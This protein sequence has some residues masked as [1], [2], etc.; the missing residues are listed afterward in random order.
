MAKKR[1]AFFDEEKENEPEVKIVEKIVEKLVIPEE[2]PGTD[3]KVTMR[4]NGVGR[5]YHVSEVEA[6]QKEGW[7]LIG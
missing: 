3:G 6:R 7:E 4:K 2:I 5:R 1:E